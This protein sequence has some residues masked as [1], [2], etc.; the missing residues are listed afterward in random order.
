MPTAG[1]GHEG[2]PFAVRDERQA[3]TRREHLGVRSGGKIHR[4]CG[5]TPSVIELLVHVA[6]LACR[7]RPERE[8]SEARGIDRQRLAVA[9]TEGEVVVQRAAVAVL[10]GADE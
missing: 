10:A 3:I 8:L 9:A 5:R 2:V 1:P 7:V 6:R 4:R